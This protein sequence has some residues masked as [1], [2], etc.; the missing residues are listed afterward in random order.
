M[1]LQFEVD[2]LDGVPEALQDQ[3]T[4]TDNGT[5]RLAVDGYEDPSGLKTALEKERGEKKETAKQL[6]EMRKQFEG[7]DPDRTREIF[8]RLEQD[9]EARLIADGKVDEVVNQRT[10]RMRS[11]YDRKLQSMEE[12]AEKAKS[13]AN[14]FRTRVLSDEVRGAAS[15]VGLVDSAVSDAVYRAKDLFQVDDEGNVVPTEDAGFDADGKPLTLKSWLDGMR[16]SAPH[17]FPVPKGGGAPG[18]DGTRSGMKRS[19]MSP[20]QKYAYIRK[21]GQDAYLNLPA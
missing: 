5:F 9:E 21:N 15:E 14:K 20:E 13:F 12:E 1:A 11:E 17:W 18:N 16:E 3:Y 2:S 6:R 8:Q 10:E 7:I 4:E 19:D